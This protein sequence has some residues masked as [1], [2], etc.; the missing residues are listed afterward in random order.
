MLSARQPWTPQNSLVL[1]AAAIDTAEQ[2]S[3]VCAAAIDEDSLV[4]ELLDRAGLRPGDLLTH[5]DAI[6]V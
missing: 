4:R 2:P 5:V 6:P 1:S 3:A